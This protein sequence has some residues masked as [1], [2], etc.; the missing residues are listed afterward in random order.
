MAEHALRVHGVPGQ[1]SKAERPPDPPKGITDELQVLLPREVEETK[2]VGKSQ[3]TDIDHDEP[4]YHPDA[5]SSDGRGRKW[6]QNGKSVFFM[7][8]PVMRRMRVVSVVAA[9]PVTTSTEKESQMGTQP[10]RL[11]DHRALA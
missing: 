1:E 3:S 10:R 4:V 11:M 2:D 7:F 6:H 9:K 8:L 5:A